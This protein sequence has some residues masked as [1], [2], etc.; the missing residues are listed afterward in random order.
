VELRRL[1]YR[2]DVRDRRLPVEDG[3]GF[4]TPHRTKVFAES[5]LELCDAYLLHD[6]IMTI[7]SHN[8]KKT[9]R[10]HAAMSDQRF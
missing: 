7:T 10:L 3:D 8:R 4:A 5:C 6:H 9:L 2:N 1:A